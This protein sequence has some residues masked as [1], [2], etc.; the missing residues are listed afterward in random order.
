M[1]TITYVGDHCAS[2]GRS[3]QRL[4]LRGRQDMEPHSER[5]RANDVRVKNGQRDSRCGCGSS[6]EDPRDNPRFGRGG[7]P[8]KRTLRTVGALSH[9]T[10]ARLGTKK[11]TRRSAGAMA[12]GNV[13]SASRRNPLRPFLI[14]CSI[15]SSP[16]PVPS[17]AKRRIGSTMQRTEKTRTESDARRSALM[18]AAQTGDR[19]AYETLLRDCVS[20]IVDIARRQGVPPTALTTWCKR[21][22]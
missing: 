7:K 18:A 10:F 16:M 9:V 12:Q 21:C 6:C 5:C 13:I 8:P 19:A 14:P 11:D 20:F 1:A 15:P 17:K 4:H 2:C 22:C 3:V